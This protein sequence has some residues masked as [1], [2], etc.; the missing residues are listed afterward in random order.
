ML[1]RVGKRLY[2]AKE[3]WGKW[4]FDASLTTPPSSSNTT[5]YYE[6][7]DYSSDMTSGVTYRIVATFEADGESVTKTSNSFTY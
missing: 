6:S 7:K 2:A 4:V 3:G 5:S 1:D